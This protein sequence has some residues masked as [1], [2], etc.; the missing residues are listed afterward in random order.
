MN[1]T[2]R[3]IMN[4]AHSSGK[5]G[6]S[7]PTTNISVRFVADEPLDLQIKNHMKTSLQE[8]PIHPALFRIA[9]I[10]ENPLTSAAGKSAS[11]ILK[12]EFAAFRKAIAKSMAAGTLKSRSKMS[13]TEAC[14]WSFPIRK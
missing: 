12:K 11:S 10:I 2:S 9:A 14:G 4:P 7:Y 8:N 6:A 5:P 13:E 1:A 3:Q